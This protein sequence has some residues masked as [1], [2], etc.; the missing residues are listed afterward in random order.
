[1]PDEYD[2]GYVQPQPK[3]DPGERG[4]FRFEP[5]FEGFTPNVAPWEVLREGSFGGT[6]WR[7]ASRR[8]APLFLLPYTRALDVR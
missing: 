2:P 6:Y 8:C 7:C 3:R 5:G 1:M 4:V